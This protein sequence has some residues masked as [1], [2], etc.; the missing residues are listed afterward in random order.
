M[1]RLTITLLTLAIISSCS[2]KNDVVITLEC[3]SPYTTER[4]AAFN[5][6]Q[7]WA[8]QNR[9][10]SVEATG[11]LGD[12]IMLSI[13]ESFK[14]FFEE[15]VEDNLPAE[16]YAFTFNKSLMSKIGTHKVTSQGGICELGG[17]ESAEIYEDLSTMKVTENSLQFE[18]GLRV[19]KS[20]LIGSKLWK[21]TSE[22]TYGPFKFICKEKKND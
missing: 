20:N 13:L 3:E 5:A 15:C 9:D 7:Q 16:N 8:Y 18:N 21:P 6:H 12:T 17:R 4:I 10:T 19:S 1:K 14:E 11:G 22:T 2:D